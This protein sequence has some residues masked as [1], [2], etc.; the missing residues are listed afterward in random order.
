MPT[1]SAAPWPTKNPGLLDD[2]RQLLNALEYKS[3]RT[4]DEIFAPDEFLREFKSSRDGA[5]ERELCECAENIGI[6]FQ[7][8][9]EEIRQT[10]PYSPPTSSGTTSAVLSLSPP[11]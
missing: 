7:V 11:I 9:D 5:N 1:T 3:D 10:P 2:A 6:V 8:G 4:M